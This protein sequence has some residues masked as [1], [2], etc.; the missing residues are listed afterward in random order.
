[1]Q[2]ADGCHR[3]IIPVVKYRNDTAIGEYDTF[4]RKNTRL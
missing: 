1:M 2:S 4:I 3:V